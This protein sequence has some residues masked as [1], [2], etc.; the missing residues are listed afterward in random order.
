MTFSLTIVIQHMKHL[1]LR[2]IY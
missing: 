2:R 1:I